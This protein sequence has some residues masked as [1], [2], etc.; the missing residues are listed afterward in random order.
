MFGQV[1][2]GCRIVLFSPFFGHV[3][4]LNVTLDR[5]AVT[6]CRPAMSAASSGKERYSLPRT[7]QQM[8][9]LS[10]KFFFLA[11]ALKQGRISRAL[12]ATP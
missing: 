2:N 5:S 6:L 7:H 11:V 12:R 8:T 3:A 1:A 9:E 4:Q 10:G